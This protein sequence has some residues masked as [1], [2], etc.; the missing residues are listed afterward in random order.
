MGVRTNLVA[1]PLGEAQAVATTGLTKQSPGRSSGCD[2][3]IASAPRG[4]VGASGRR[5]G[6]PPTGSIVWED[7]WAK[8]KPIG[9]RVTGADG[10]RKLVRFDPGTSAEAAIALAP[11]LAMRANNDTNVGTAKL[12][13]YSATWLAERFAKGLA[14]APEDKRRLAKHILPD[15]GPFDVRTVT[16]GDLIAFVDRL[17]RKVRAGTLGAKTALHVWSNVR[18]MLRE[19]SSSKRRELRVR[20]DNPALGVRGPDRGVTKARQYLYPSEFLALVSCERVPLRWRRL[21]ALGAYTYARTGELAALRWEDVDVEHG[22]LHI[23]GA[24]DRVRSPGDVKSTKTKLSR[25]IPIEPTLL[26][27]LQAMHT[28]CDGAGSVIA[29]PSAGMLARRLRVFLERA[30]I[31][32][33]DLFVTDATRKAITFHDAT[34]ATG[35]TWAAV[36]GDGPVRLMQR[37]GHSSFQTT[38]GYIREAENLSSAFGEPFGPLPASLLGAQEVSASL[39][40]FGFVA[41][42]AKPKKRGAGW[43]QQDLNASPK[44]GETRRTAA[45]RGEARRAKRPLAAVRVGRRRAWRM[46]W[47]SPRKPGAGTSWRRSPDSSMPCCAPRAAGTCV[48]SILDRQTDDG[49][50]SPA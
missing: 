36:R 9:V 27:L 33:A 25:R 23:H 3:T 20:E 39:S 42:L 8:T 22:V 16:R 41:A 40:A 29:L 47:R 21:F 17:D 37:A 45:K 12:A 24:V 1:A 49:N 7:P 46:P 6:R 14:S 11:I 18:A 28:E 48:S 15:L 30:G 31:T 19:A 10:R 35:I 26:P 50:G 34:R 44:A 43:A 4:N 38:L 32:R 5:G 13:D 2:R